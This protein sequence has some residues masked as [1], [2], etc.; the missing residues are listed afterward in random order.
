M[1][2]EIY[3]TGLDC[4]HI[5]Y[6]TMDKI[7]IKDLRVTAIIGIHAYERITPQEMIINLVLFTDTRHAAETDNIQDCVNYQA[8]AEQVRAHTLTSKRLTVE[9]LA[10]DLA[11]ICLETSGVL[12]VTVRVGKTQAIAYARAVGVEIE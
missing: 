8:V 6:T 11:R 12:R 4:L 3:A 1:Q 5:G 2:S 9:A 10:E 7:F